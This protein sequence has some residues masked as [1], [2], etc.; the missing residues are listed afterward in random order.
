MSVF[1]FV[2]YILS[3]LLCF[4]YI[5][6]VQIKY[7]PSCIS[8]T[9]Y[10][11]PNGNLFSGWIIGIGATLLPCWL[12]VSPESME[13][14]AFLSVVALAIVGI[15]PRYLEENRKVHIA[16]A[17]VAIGL[18][19]LWEW[20]LGEWMVLLLLVGIALIIYW[21]KRKNGLFLM[22]AMAF[23][24]IYLSILCLIDC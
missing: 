20:L 3:A 6:A 4:G 16:G 5:I 19:I 1:A 8:E 10:L 11:L 7:S 18:S 17:C 21:M 2:C 24:N 9:Y 15:A 22:E 23:L 14:M 12:E 13:F